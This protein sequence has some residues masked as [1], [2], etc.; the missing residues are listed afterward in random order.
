MFYNLPTENPCLWP[1]YRT[2]NVKK[3][4]LGKIRAMRG[5]SCPAGSTVSPCTVCKSVPKKIDPVQNIPCAKPY[6][7]G[8]K[9]LPK[10]LHCARIYSKI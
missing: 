4:T 1:Y 7:K 5:N 9:L 10:K 3:N 6:K 2:K 8:P